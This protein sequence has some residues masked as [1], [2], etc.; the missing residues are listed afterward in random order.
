[1]NVKVALMLCVIFLAST[2]TTAAIAINTPTSGSFNTTK[3]AFETHNTE[4]GLV[5]P[6]GDPID[7]PLF[8]GTT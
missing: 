3:T 4:F 7:D 5:K 8:P 1:M 2:I 6:I